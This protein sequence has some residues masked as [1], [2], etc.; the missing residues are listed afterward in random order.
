MT[1]TNSLFDTAQEILKEARETL[2][3]E[4]RSYPSP[5]SGCDAQ[6]NH[7]LAER[8]RAHSALAALSEEIHIPTPRQP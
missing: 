4:I 1:S 8:R 7:L 3:S 6:Y 2:D 5:I